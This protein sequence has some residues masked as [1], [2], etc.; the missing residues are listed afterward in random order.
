MADGAARL[1]EALHNRHDTGLLEAS[2]HRLED[3]VAQAEAGAPFVVRLAQSVIEALT[4]LG[5]LDG[6]CQ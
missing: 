3:L 4:D 6:P 1:A 2:R 5:I